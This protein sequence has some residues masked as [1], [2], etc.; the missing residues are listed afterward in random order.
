MRKI[1]FI[2]FIG[3]LLISF[4]DPAKAQVSLS[5][6]INIRSQTVW[7]PTGYNEVQYYYLPD[8]EVYN[9]ATQYRFY[10]QSGGYRRYSSNLLYIYHNY[11]L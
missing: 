9:Y 7:G 4:S 8:M 1:N 5:F 3:E 6:G 11:E 10:Y 2:I